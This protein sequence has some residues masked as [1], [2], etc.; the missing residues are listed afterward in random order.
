MNLK[1]ILGRISKGETFEATLDDGSFTLKISKYVPYV[2]MAVHHGSRMRAELEPHC[3]LSEFQRWYE[4]DPFTGDMIQSLP[5][6]LIAHDSRY[7]YD[8]NRAPELAIYEFAWGVKVWKRKLSAKQRRVSLQKHENFYKVVHAIIEKL[9]T[10]FDAALVIDLH[11]YNYKRWPREV[12]HFNVGTEKVDRQKFGKYIDQWMLEL[13]G[14]KVPDGQCFT[15]ENDVFFGRGYVLQYIQEHFNNTLVLATEVKKF[16]CNEETGD[17]YPKVIELL[18]V[19]LKKAIL[20]IANVFGKDLQQWQHITTAKLL[21]KGLDPA[22]LKIDRRLH[23]ALKNFEL[24]ATVNPNNVQ[25]EKRRFLKGKF[26]ERPKFNYNPV[27]VSSFELKQHI[28]SNNFQEISDVSVRHLYET[29]VNSYF[30]KMDMINSLNT[31]NFL[32]NSLRYFGRPSSKDLINAEYLLHLPDIPG[33]AKKEPLLGIEEAK[34]FFQESLD[35]Y[36]IK[37]KIGVSSKVISKVM[38]LNSKKSVLFQPGATFKRKQL[39]A[40]IEHEIG[41]HMVTTMNSNLQPL[42]IFNLGLPVNTRTQEGLAI[43]AEYL[44]GNITLPRLKQLAL[45]VIAVDAMCNGAD[46]VE[47]F[48]LLRLKHGT[49]PESAFDIVTRVYRG[50]GF[51]KDYLYLSGFVKILRFWQ[52]QNNLAPLLVGKT[53]LEFYGVIDEMIEREMIL[54]PQYMTHSILHPKPEN[55]HEVYSY[56]L[57]G[58]K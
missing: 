22:L 15:T 24:L 49:A 5:I 23:Q 53:S 34:V 2:C 31:K 12:P 38:V 26:T 3:S 42:K 13:Q 11:S 27:K 52:N 35:Q 8:L 19:Q 54:P 7:E 1:E 50:G 45:R 32:Y 18:K 20:N 10:L 40:L 6:T 37:A 14:I 36:G 16:Y 25:R 17:A 44:S 55:N 57:S 28:I 48:N 56:I 9:E 29:V 41:I 51:T 43:L 33:E 4:E 21:N 58:L 47:C 39:Q 46:F 30:D